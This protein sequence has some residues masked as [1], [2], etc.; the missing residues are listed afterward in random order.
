M[1]NAT[2]QR[3]LQFADIGPDVAVDMAQPYLVQRT[4]LL[5]ID[6]VYPNSNPIEAECR[7]VGL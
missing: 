4:F 2:L 6:R 1:I 3:R 5:W 7:P